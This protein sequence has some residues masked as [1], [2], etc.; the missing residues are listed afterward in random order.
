M[1][2]TSRAIREKEINERTTE[3]YSQALK[4]YQRAV[5]VLER[6]ANHTVSGEGETGSFSSSVDDS[7][8]TMTRSWLAKSKGK[9]SETHYQMAEVN[10]ESIDRLLSAPV[11]AD[12][13]GV[14]RLEYRSQV[15]VKAIKP[16]LDVVVGAHRRNLH[17]ADSLGLKNQ[18]TE[19]S[20]SKILSSLGLL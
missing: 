7:V 14:A 4:S 12:L 5:L 18:W 10:T 20:R 9:I 15:L 3:I 2:P 13:G 16:L 11:P 1:D 6:V 17:V 8:L 19:A